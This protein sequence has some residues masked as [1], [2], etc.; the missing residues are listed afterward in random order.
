MILKLNQVL[1]ML[2][3][4]WKGAPM[5]ELHTDLKAISSLL[6]M[7]RHCSKWEPLRVSHYDLKAIY[8]VCYQW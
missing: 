1:S 2:R 3:H 6:S 5:R 4:W 8:L 7:V